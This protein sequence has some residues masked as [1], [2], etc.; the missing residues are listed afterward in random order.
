VLR[1][2][3]VGPYT[4]RAGGAPSDFIATDVPDPVT[5]G[6]GAVEIRVVRGVT[7]SGRLVDAKGAPIRGGLVQVTRHGERAVSDE[8]GRFTIRAL[9]S[10]RFPLFAQIGSRI[11]VLGEVDVPGDGL[12]FT[13]RDE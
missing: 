13:I 8:T 4:L 10:G 2:L 9:A 1:G 12:E 11:V 6:A 7:L 5:P 3:A